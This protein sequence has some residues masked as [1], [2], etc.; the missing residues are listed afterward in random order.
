MRSI[1]R[2]ISNGFFIEYFRRYEAI[3]SLSSSPGRL[4][5]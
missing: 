1:A 4:L 3:I 2:S 5:L